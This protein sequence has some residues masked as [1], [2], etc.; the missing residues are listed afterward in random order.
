MLAILI[1]FAGSVCLAADDKKDEKK[2]EK[3]TV[4]E[5]PTKDLKIMFS[6]REKGKATEPTTITSAEDLA[7]NAILKDAADDIAK[8]IDFA[9]Q[10][11]VVFAWPGS[12]GDKLT[13]SIGAEG[14]KSI[15]YVEYIRGRTRDLRPHVHLFVVPKDLKVVVDTGK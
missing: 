11:L 6:V 3:P 14:G 7:K 2:D 5:I 4:K 8:Q 12:G 1:V 15:V 13:A 9:K 10:K